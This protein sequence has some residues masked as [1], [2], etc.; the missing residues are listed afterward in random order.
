MIRKEGKA[1]KIFSQAG[2]DD[3]IATLSVR[4]Q[5]NVVHATV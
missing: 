3:D 4:Q 1:T 5:T 2:T